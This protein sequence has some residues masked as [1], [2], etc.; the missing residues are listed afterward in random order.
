MG[1]FSWLFANS[2]KPLNMGMRGYL[3]L[4]DEVDGR[5]PNVIE[6]HDYDGVG[7]FGGSDVFE[8]VA[9]WNRQYLS[10][11]PEYM[12]PERG[13]VK[14]DL[15]HEEAKPIRIDSLF[16]YKYYQDLSLTPE[17]VAKKAYADPANYV[18]RIKSQA[19]F[20]YRQI[21]IAL[22]SSNEQN[23]WLPYPIKITGNG[24][25]DYRRLPP[26]KRDPGQGGGRKRNAGADENDYIPSLFPLPPHI[27]P[28]CGGT[29]FYATAHVTQ[30]WVVDGYGE[31]QETVN[32]C[33]EVTHY[34]DNEDL[35]E[36]KT[37]GLEESGAFFSE[38]DFTAPPHDRFV[39]RIYDRNL[40]YFK[41]MPGLEVNN[42]KVVRA[43]QA[44]T[45]KGLYDLWFS[46]KMKDWHYPTHVYALKDMKSGL[47]LME[48]TLPKSEQ[49]SSEE[50]QQFRTQL[51]RLLRFPEDML[52]QK[53]QVFYV[54]ADGI[55]REPAFLT[56]VEAAARVE[57]LRKR[58]KQE[59][60]A[61]GTDE[62]DSWHVKYDVL[63]TEE[64]VAH[65]SALNI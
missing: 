39:L 28:R 58:Q 32:E 57:E 53:L 60:E 7:T 16:W 55:P 56:R 13:Y 31:F 37:C 41:G 34:P 6:E 25:E 27:C 35:W 11:H 5:C 36:C 61:D 43:L 65:C 45:L 2:G 64:Y 52:S 18:E 59:E 62:S 19:P 3:H 63:E 22:A 47:V 20:E 51:E 54:T 50:L 42:G 17:E 24:R 23:A 9:N 15:S 40:P 49:E 38:T 46:E 33:G 26:S 30:D 14:G 21:G 12:I 8:L 10:A 48:G 44:N 29:M 1:C 4:P